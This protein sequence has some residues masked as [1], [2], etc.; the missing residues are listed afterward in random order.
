MEWY[1]PTGIIVIGIL[2]AYVVKYVVN[3]HYGKQLNNIDVIESACMY[4]R[5]DFGLLEGAE[6]GHVIFEAR[7]WAR[8]FDKAIE[9]TRS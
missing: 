5:H 2:I 7:E 4:Y 8:A 1:I 3:K 9:D 6:R